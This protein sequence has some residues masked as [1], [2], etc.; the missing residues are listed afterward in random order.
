MVGA[1][2]DGASVAIVSVH[3]LGAKCEK[4]S[5]SISSPSPSPSPSLALVYKQLAVEV[6]MMGVVTNSECS[7]QKFGIHHI[8]LTILNFFPCATCL[9]TEMDVNIIIFLCMWLFTAKNCPLSRGIL[10]WR[11]Y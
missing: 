2:D 7:H 9:F 5:F 3:L 1:R 11:L 6:D 4:I 10:Y 8:G